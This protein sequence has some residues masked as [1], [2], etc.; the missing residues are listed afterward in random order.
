MGLSRRA[1]VVASGRVATTASILI[2]N[3][4]LAR[5]WAPGVF[6]HFS[7]IW[8]LGNTL[9]PFFLLGIPGALLYTL[10]RQDPDRRP[11]LLLQTSLVL[12]L[13]GIVLCLAVWIGTP[14]IA[15]HV[16]DLSVPLLRDQLLAFLPYVFCL[17]A[18]G[19]AEAALVAAGRHVWQAIVAWLGAAVVIGGASAAWALGWSVQ[20]TFLVLSAA[21]VARLLFAYVAL[22]RVGMCA[23]GD[24]AGLTGFLRYAVTIGVGEGVGSVS[25]SVDRLVVLLFLD[26]DRLGIYHL[27]AIEVPVSLILASL[28]TVM[29]PEVSRLM[30]AERHGQ[31]ADLFRMAVVRL[32][33]LILPLFFFLFVFTDD[34]MRLYLPA[35]Y[36]DSAGVFRCFLLMLPLRCAVYNPILVGSGRAGWALAGSVGDLVLNGLMSVGLVLWLRE[37]HPGWSMLGPAVATVVATHLQVAGLL[38]VIAHLVRRPFWQ[39]VPWGH[40]VRVSV[41]ALIAALLSHWVMQTLFDMTLVRVLAGG[42]LTALLAFLVPAWLFVD[43][44]RQLREIIAALRQRESVA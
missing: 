4:L 30:A 14:Y 19:H 8:V 17:V 24:S 40:L 9:V 11:R 16:E 5:A 2:V 27:G 28:V 29:V 35:A 25:R 22:L 1:A 37:A 20:E 21:G 15:R 39:L 13:S 41:F 26:P 31:V 23:G 34:V 10:P 7:A 32:S 43:D 3:A 12:A 18:G 33:W 38:L 44:R 42:M 36:A 6:G